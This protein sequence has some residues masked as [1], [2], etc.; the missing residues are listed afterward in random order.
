LVGVLVGVSVFV[1]VLVGVIVGVGVVVSV[2][3]G[4]NPIVADADGVCVTV[5]V[6]VGVFVGVVVGVTGILEDDGVGVTPI[7]GNTPSLVKTIPVIN[8]VEYVS[9]INQ[10]FLV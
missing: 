3:V 8:D 10:I 4:V 9:S 1:G 7:G 2:A 6:F 5:G